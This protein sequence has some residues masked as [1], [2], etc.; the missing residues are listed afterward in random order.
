MLSNGNAFFQNYSGRENTGRVTFDSSPEKTKM[1]GG[2]ASRSM[3][4]SGGGSTQVSTFHLI[5]VQL[6]II[7][8][9]YDI[10]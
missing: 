10:K 2:A 1:Y 4:W 3:A 5:M 9:V 7:F 8:I 6:K